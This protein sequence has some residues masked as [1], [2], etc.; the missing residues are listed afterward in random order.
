MDVTVKIGHVC[1]GTN[2]HVELELYTGAQ[3]RDTLLVQKSDIT[4][5][6]GS[7]D[8]AVGALI[9]LL[10]HSVKT[11]LSANPGASLNQIKTHIEGEVFKI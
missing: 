11:F 5:R 3:K 1:T 4:T 9:A 2:P 7:Y 6:I 10:R 8:E